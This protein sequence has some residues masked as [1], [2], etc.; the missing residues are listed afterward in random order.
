M[1]N[2]DQSDE[3]GK[4]VCSH[5]EDWKDAQTV[6]NQIGIPLKRASTFPT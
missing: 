4:E 3:L 5:V 6:C 2:W 1:K